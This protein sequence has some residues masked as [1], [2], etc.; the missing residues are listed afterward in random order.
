MKSLRTS[1]KVMI[2]MGISLNFTKR[3]NDIIY[4]EILVYH[5][6][7]TTIYLNIKRLEL[8]GSIIYGTRKKAVYLEMIWDLERLFRLLSTSMDSLKLR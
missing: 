8:N 6:R 7:S 4:L 2:N 3:K 1:P 5:L